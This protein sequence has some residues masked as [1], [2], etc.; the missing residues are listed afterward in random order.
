MVYM[1]TSFH[2]SVDKSDSPIGQYVAL[3][4]LNPAMHKASGMR[5]CAIMSRPELTCIR[6]KRL[7]LRI[8]KL[9][10]TSN[11]SGVATMSDLRDTAL[12]SIP[13]RIRIV[14][15]E[16]DW[17]SRLGTRSAQGRPLSDYVPTSSIGQHTQRN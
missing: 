14:A 7:D 5:R 13:E 4:L 8:P 1:E 2:D 12:S 16:H 6:V 10:G 9:I 3:R 15:G 11:L 17:R